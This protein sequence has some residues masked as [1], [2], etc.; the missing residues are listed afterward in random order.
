MEGAHREAYPSLPVR[1][2]LLSLIFVAGWNTIKLMVEAP[3]TPL[4]D[5][6]SGTSTTIR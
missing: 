4:A 2:Q 3:A 5:G 1:I 6:L